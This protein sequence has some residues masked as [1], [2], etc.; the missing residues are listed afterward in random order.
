STDPPDCERGERKCQ[1]LVGKGRAPEEEHGIRGV[2]QACYRCRPITARNPLSDEVEAHGEQE[3]S[4]S[5]NDCASS[6]RAE[7]G[8][9]DET[10]CQ[11]G[12]TGIVRGRGQ[13]GVVGEQVMR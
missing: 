11:S 7:T 1:I 3:T 8:E 12:E 13:E 6:K 4:N 5:D 10:G 9:I 2:D